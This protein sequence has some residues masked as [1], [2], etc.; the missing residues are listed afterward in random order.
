[1][2][3]I[4]KELLRQYADPT[5]TRATGGSDEARRRLLFHGGHPAVECTFNDLGETHV[6]NVRHDGAVKG[7]DP[8]WVLEMP[9]RVD[10]TASSPYRL[11]RCPPVCFGL[12]AQRKAFELLTIEAAV[13]VTA[14]RPT[15]RC[16]RTRWVRRPTRWA[17]FLRI[18]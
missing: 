6:C 10:R 16:W 7:W 15:R 14:R 1:M 4:E 17:R 3:G 12:L 13:K 5:L 11:S 9:C 8:E 18:C 2:I